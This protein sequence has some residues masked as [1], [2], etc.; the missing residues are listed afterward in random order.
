M[1]ET[2]LLYRDSGNHILMPYI[3]QVTPGMIW[4]TQLSKNALRG[5]DPF[6][7]MLKITQTLKVMMYS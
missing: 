4:T 6:R 5:V 7:K 1:D 3:G 2:G